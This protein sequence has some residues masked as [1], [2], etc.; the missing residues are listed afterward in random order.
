MV[1]HGHLGEVSSKDTRDVVGGENF[2]FP[3]EV[4]AVLEF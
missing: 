4:F 3:I 2:V 1:A